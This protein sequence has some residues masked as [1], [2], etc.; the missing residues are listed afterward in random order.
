MVAA[1]MPAARSPA[2]PAR[3]R[4]PRPRRR[5]RPWRAPPPPQRL[6]VSHR[7]GDSLPQ[8]VLG[9][10]ALP[11]FNA[12]CTASC[13]EDRRDPTHGW[14]RCLRRGR[15]GVS[16]RAG[17]H[18]GRRALS[19]LLGRHPSRRP[20]RHSPCRRRLHRPSLSGG[21][22]RSSSVRSSC[23]FRSLLGPVGLGLALGPLGLCCRRLLLGGRR[24]L[25]QQVLLRSALRRLCAAATPLSWFGAC[26][27][28]GST[29]TVIQAGSPAL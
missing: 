4:S 22:S 13:R 9:R 29:A 25:L 20:G 28:R 11:T 19:R 24:L 14:Q 7:R 6:P 27:K 8:S 5:P 10:T 16:A 12:W 2:D 18:R 1:S 23:C 26:M 17:A 3:L 21:L 15:V